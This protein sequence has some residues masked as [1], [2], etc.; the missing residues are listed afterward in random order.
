MYIHSQT[1]KCNWAIKSVK[2][3]LWTEPAIFNP[4]LN[5]LSYY[6]AQLRL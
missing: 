2:N 6:S 1:P 5:V 3:N 4:T